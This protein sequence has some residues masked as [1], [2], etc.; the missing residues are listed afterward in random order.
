MIFLT[1]LFVS[2]VKIIFFGPLSSCVPSSSYLFPCILF[3]LTLVYIT[4]RLWSEL[5]LHQERL[6][7]SSH[8]FCIYVRLEC[9]QSDIIQYLQVSS[10]CSA[11][12]N[13]FGS[14]CSSL[15]VLASCKKPP[16]FPLFHFFFL[17]QKV[18]LI[19]HLFPHPLLYSNSIWSPNRICFLMLQS[20]P[21]FHHT[22]HQLP[23]QDDHLSAYTLAKLVSLFFH[24]M[25]R[26]GSL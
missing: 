11:V 12:S 14:M 15:S 13:G 8:D 3:I 6:L 9:S 20:I 18:K 24:K 21:L 19:S 1:S 17:I 23:H 7:N 26:N 2:V 22:T 25:L 5:A 16:V 4:M 10:T